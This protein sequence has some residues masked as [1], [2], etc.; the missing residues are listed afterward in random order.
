MGR[1]I[2]ITGNS[3]LKKEQTELVLTALTKRSETVMM[4]IRQTKVTDTKI[5]V[6]KKKNHMMVQLLEMCNRQLRDLHLSQNQ[7]NAGTVL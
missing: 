4:K 1:G 5:T 3:F 6:M 2:K 7:Q